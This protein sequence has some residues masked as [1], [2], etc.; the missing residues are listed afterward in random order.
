M[1]H[2]CLRRARYLID[3]AGRWARYLIDLAGRG[4]R[5]ELIGLPNRGTRGGL[6][7]DSIAGSGGALVCADDALAAI[8]LRGIRDPTGA[9]RPERLAAL[10]AAIVDY[11]EL[12]GSLLA[13]CSRRAGPRGDDRTPGASCPSETSRR[14]RTWHAPHGA[15]RRSRSRRS[16]PFAAST[17]WLQD[18]SP[19]GRRGLQGTLEDFGLLDAIVEVWLD[20]RAM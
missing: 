7:A 16:A 13:R 5:S 3:L 18:D 19:P 15:R 9:L 14:F 17:S 10:M 6:L 2:G 1:S 8:R 4:A 12:I 20:R 11:A